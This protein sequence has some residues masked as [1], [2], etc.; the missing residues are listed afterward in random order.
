MSSLRCV[1]VLS[2]VMVLGTGM[3]VS[4]QEPKGVGPSEPKG[5][6][7]RSSVEG[8]SVIIYLRPEGVQLEKGELVCEL[9]SSGFRDQLAN[10]KPVIATS[11]NAYRNA[12]VE[13]EVSE[14][15]VTEYIEGTYR[16]ESESIRNEITKAQTVLKQAEARLERSNRLFAKSQ[17]SKA[18]NSADK[19]YLD[20][21]KAAMER[22]QNKLNV[23][24]RYTK[25]LRIKKLK[26]D[27]EKAKGEESIKK[28]ILTSGKATEER[29]AR[30]VA[31][32]KLLAPVNGR[33]HYPRP[34]EA[35]STVGLRQLVFL[36][37]P[38]EGPKADGVKPSP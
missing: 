31:N 15:A 37:I 35:G 32:C 7:V 3:T 29:L 9:D 1:G 6:E 10:Q 12:K 17:V 8:R 4:A 20:Q 16:L 13:R 14:I 2:G 25:E 28:A 26:S 5:I 24:E 22:A 34:I 23:L 18:Q 11:E 21:K 33:V 36:M 19:D 30:Q 38:D 27:V